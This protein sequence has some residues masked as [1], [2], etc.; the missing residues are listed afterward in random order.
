MRLLATLLLGLCV[1]APAAAS[2]RDDE[3][4]VSKTV[5]ATDPIRLRARPGETGRVIARANK[6]DELH[7]IAQWGRWVKVRHGA[8]AGWVP[9]TQVATREAD[10]PRKRDHRS[11]F[12]GKP[13]ADALEVTVAIDN[14][15]GF[16]DPETK[17]KLVLELKRGDKATVI[18][19][20]HDGWI[21]V[22]QSGTV[23]WIPSSAVAD[24]GEFA[25]DPRRSPSELEAERAADVVIIT[26]EEREE[27]GPPPRVVAAVVAG[28]GGQT[29][30]MRQ[31]G[32]GA[33]LATASGPAS[34]VSAHA[35][36]RVA[37]KI[38]VG[39]DT[40][41]AMGTAS[42]LYAADAGELSAP[43]STR[44]T[45]VDAH[46]SVGW[47]HEWQV[48]A[49]A[50]YHYASLDVESERGESMLVGEKL[51]GPTVGVGGAMPLGRFR[52]ALGLDVMPAGA[53]RP[54]ELPEGVMYATSVHAA[55]ANGTL[56]MP[57]PA[58]IVLAL[59]YRGGLT[60]AALTDGAATPSTASRTDQSH[61]L[62]AGLGLRW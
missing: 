13:R 8:N 9:R 27:A 40:D 42:L 55:W 16:D 53:L 36:V 12:S 62:T 15:R 25:G 49:R 34:M 59:A 19:H 3:D 21:L 26:S 35:H 51:G 29:F 31:S 39:G 10:K 48:L 23:G 7:V 52:L 56:S 30:A 38:W 61:T 37:G 44:G 57:L 60:S 43:M 33:A 17:S 11:G 18:G 22:E 28:V 4:V 5:W 58:R 45:A 24:G 46:A 32:T 41:A 14:V 1:A 54:S 20:G 47:G 2:P 6:N 50:G